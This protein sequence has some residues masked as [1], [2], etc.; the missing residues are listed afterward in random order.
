MYV[1]PSWASY[2]IVVVEVEKSLN[3]RSS[4]VRPVVRYPLNDR[5]WDR[6]CHRSPFWPV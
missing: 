1:K 6:S 4:I 5:W 3:D 2:V